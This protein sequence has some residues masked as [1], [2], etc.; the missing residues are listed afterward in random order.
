ME[1]LFSI[2]AGVIVGVLAARNRN[3][4][5]KIVSLCF[6][7]GAA[8]AFGLIYTLVSGNTVG[9]SASP[10]WI[11]VGIVGGIFGVVTHHILVFVL[12]RIATAMASSHH[13]ETHET[14][15]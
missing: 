11:V 7:G 4:Y 9:T 10:M 3:E 1:M 12:N 2:M 6:A 15:H 8:T 13:N 14:A 5:E